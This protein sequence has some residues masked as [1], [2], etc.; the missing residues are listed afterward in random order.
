MGP[1]SLPFLEIIEIPIKTREKTNIRV[2][3]ALIFGVTPFLIM[4]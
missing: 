1:L 2:E 4:L 3:T